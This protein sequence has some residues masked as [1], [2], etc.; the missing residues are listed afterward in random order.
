MRPS[1]TVCD[2]YLTDLSPMYL[3]RSFHSNLDADLSFTRI[4]GCQLL[5]QPIHRLIH[6]SFDLIDTT[7]VLKRYNRM[8][9]HVQIDVL[10]RE[11][12]V[13]FYLEAL[14]PL[15][16]KAVNL[17]EKSGVGSGPIKDFPLWIRIAKGTEKPTPIHI[18]FYVDEKSK[19]DQFH[20][21]AIAAGGKD[22]GGPGFRNIMKGYYGEPFSLFRHFFMEQ[23]G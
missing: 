17:P 6:T 9:G 4:Q 18:A 23:Y 8:L 13:K 20:A 14:S 3:N 15:S 10:D 19:V 21:K 2:Y 5:L 22:N 1:S 12:T 16:Y 11:A 7:V